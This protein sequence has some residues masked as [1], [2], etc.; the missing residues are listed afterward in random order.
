[1]S[2]GREIGTIVG[3]LVAAYFTAG[4]SY[5][6]LAVAAGGA[7]GGAIGGALDPT[8]IV[9]PRLDDLKVTISTYGA[10][11]P[12]I[13]GT[14]RLGGIV[15]WTTDRQ[16]VST[17][18]DVGKGSG[19]ENTSFS[20]YVH[21]RILLAERRSDGAPLTLI[22]GFQDGKLI[23][24]ASSGIPLGQALAN[25]E[26]PFASAV[27]YQGED[28]QMPDPYEE[29]FLGAGN[30]DAYRDYASISLRFIG[31]PGGRIPQF[32][33]VV[34]TNGDD[35]MVVEPFAQ[36]STAAGLIMSDRV[37]PCGLLNPIGSEFTFYDSGPGY[38]NTLPTIGEI[39][40]TYA[41]DGDPAPIQ[42]AMTPQYV[43]VG[44][45]TDSGVTHMDIWHVDPLTGNQSFV[46]RLNDY[47]VPVNAFGGAAYDPVT[48]KYALGMNNGAN[49]DY[50]VY[51]GTELLSTL[52][53]HGQPLSGSMAFYNGRIYVLTLNGPTSGTLQLTEY[54][55]TTAIPATYSTGFAVA[56]TAQFH[57]SS[58]CANEHG[59]FLL[60]SIGTPG[61]DVLLRYKGFGQFETMLSNVLGVEQPKSTWAIVGKNYGSALTLYVDDQKVICGPSV[62]NGNIYSIILFNRHSYNDVLVKDVIAREIDRIGESRYSVADIPDSDVITGRKVATQTTTR[63]AIDPLLTGFQI[64][65]V[66]E[67]GLIKFKKYKDIASVATISF[68][69]LGEGDGDADAFP[70]QRTQEIDLP[71]S[72]KIEYTQPGLD[73]N[74]ASEEERRQT[75]Q[76]IE[77]QSIQ[78]PLAMSSDIAKT[79]AQSILY[80]AWNSQN[81]RQ[82][83]VS[84]KFAYLSPGDGVTVEYPMGLMSLYRITAMQDDG[85]II[86]LTLEPGDASLY[87]K[88]AVGYADFTSQQLAGLAPQTIA[89]IVDGPILQDA[90][91]NAGL[92]VV[93]EGATNTDWNGAELWVGN[94]PEVLT[95][96]GNVRNAALQGF[97]ENALGAFASNFFDETNIL[98]V[99][100]GEGTL[101]SATH[102]AIYADQTLNAFA[103]GVNGRWEYGQ[104]A[105]AT[106]LGGGRWSLSS[107]R[108]GRRGTEHNI[109]NHAANDRFVML[110][111]AG[112]LRPAGSAADIGL[113]NY[114]RAVSQGR[115]FDSAP[116][117]SY[118]NTAEGLK[119]FSPWDARKSKASTNDQTV[120]WKRRSRLATSALK[121]IV[122]L[123]EASESYSVDFYT[124]SAFTTVAG[125]LT[126]SIQAL[127]ITSAQ[128]TSFGLTPGGTLYVRIYQLSDIVGRGHYLQATL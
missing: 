27:L 5:A 111:L 125:T 9:G 106:S 13:D 119:P 31:C 117:Q 100:I 103:L 69:E 57:C 6:A 38:I 1:M 121:G 41:L 33:F 72:V 11:I 114:Y 62:T 87:S 65:P 24:D 123:G 91:N 126:S 60:R 97:A 43:R 77:D 110:G 107:L 12:R 113:T 10:A 115:S 51:G 25:A 16:E 127:T 83:T 116:N 124:S 17:T 8:K 104:F 47:F 18:E 64:Y 128:Q 76:S 78:L 120:T 34:T 56:S 95:S 30:A 67:D 81:T 112:T 102:D 90:D 36:N 109:G 21:M 50:F 44:T 93:M 20:Y 88:T 84:R 86:T 85:R 40:A 52:P 82:A 73:F 94:S 53:K 42:G 79:A 45:Q 71:R 63:A 92:Y 96:A 61:S 66:D 98:T 7:A 23:W 75:T 49:A 58:I 99:N 108:R 29:L 68:D 89:Q 15:V 55:D 28:T 105:T 32:S 46:F 19:T 3:S 26:S 37:I 22:R 70:L 118:A 80:A 122:P 59:V 101:S 35:E 14:E 4:T 2:N 48:N 54:A 74:I 39:P